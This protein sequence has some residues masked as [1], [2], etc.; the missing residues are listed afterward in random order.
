MDSVLKD[1]IMGS[2]S[3]PPNNTHG[4]EFLQSKSLLPR[5]TASSNSYY[6]LQAPNSKALV[7]ALKTLQEKISRLEMEESQTR[8][9]LKSLSS[10]AAERKT[11]LD[12]AR[13]N[14]DPSHNEES[15]Q[16]NDVNTKL[17]AT[18]ERCSLL[19]KQLDYMRKMVQ[20]AEMEKHTTIEQENTQH[21]EV[22][23]K[24]SKLD[25]LQQEC[26][27]LSHTHRSAESK[28]QQLEQQL[29]VE[30]QQRKLLQN[31][32]AELQT[33]LEVNRI[34]LSS[35][36]KIPPRKIKKKKQVKTKA[37]LSKDPVKQV[38]PKAGQLPFVAGKSTSSSHSL[39]AN[40]QAVLHMMKHHNPRL[41]QEHRKGTVVDK[42]FRRLPPGRIMTRP[43]ALSTG[44]SLTDI[45]LA[46]QDELGQMSL[47]HQELLKMIH[48]TEDNEA[49][50]DLEREM[51]CLVKQMETKSDQILKLKRHQ[52]HAKKKKPTLPV[53]GCSAT[54]KPPVAV[55][56]VNS[57]TLSTPR[58]KPGAPARSTVTP[59][60][61]PTLQLLKNV[62]KIQMT[63]KKDDIMW[64]K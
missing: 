45:L 4:T 2:L 11:M 14:K 5:S 32:A 62:Q 49:R 19:E 3:Q 33:G 64:V 22:H 8:D 18:Q 35:A 31:K 42:G 21:K 56:R 24:L 6:I 30:E 15:L 54:M 34:L 20:N 46:L 51:E 16:K 25:L 10:E 1:S 37:A 53:K 9:R 52:E 28:I 44:D 50:E 36:Q 40:V 59:T 58:V 23:V 29:S 47:E 57:D 39:S 61:K 63:L 43:S 26:L 12:S 17:Q 38:Y 55:E 13:E 48:E 7:Q 41:N 27:R 60:S